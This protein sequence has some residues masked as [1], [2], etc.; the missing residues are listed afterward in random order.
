[1]DRERH[2]IPGRREPDLVGQ[3]PLLELDEFNRSVRLFTDEMGASADGA[4][5][6]AG[7]RWTPE[8]VGLINAV[9]KRWNGLLGVG[10]RTTFE[11]RE[12]GICDGEV[13][14]TRSFAEEVLRS[15]NFIIGHECGHE[16]ERIMNRGANGTTSG[17]KE[18]ETYY[19]AGFEDMTHMHSCPPFGETMHHDLDIRR[20]FGGEYFVRGPRGSQTRSYLQD[21]GYNARQIYCD[22]VPIK[23]IMLKEGKG[24]ISMQDIL[25]ECCVLLER[26]HE[27]L[28]MKLGGGGKAWLGVV[29]DLARYTGT[30]WALRKVAEAWVEDPA[31]S[32]EISARLERFTKM[33]GKLLLEPE[34]RQN[35]LTGEQAQNLLETP[36]LGYSGTEIPSHSKSGLSKEETMAVT[37]LTRAYKEHF[38]NCMSRKELFSDER[39]EPHIEKLNNPDE[40]IRRQEAYTLGELAS[41]RA[42]RPLFERLERENEPQVLTTIAKSIS[43]IMGKNRVSGGIHELKEDVERNLRHSNQKVILEM[44][45][46][47]TCVA[48]EQTPGK[49]AEVMRANWGANGFLDRGVDALREIG[50]A[51]GPAAEKA[52]QALVFVLND[53]LGET[54]VVSGM[55]DALGRIGSNKG[56]AAETAYDKLVEVIEANP[57]NKEI[58]ISGVFALGEIGSSENPKADKVYEEV[59]RIMNRSPYTYFVQNLGLGTLGKIACT[60]NP[61]AVKAYRKMVSM[62]GRSQD[63]ETQLARVT[64][65]SRVGS[66]KGRMARQAIDDL[67]LEIESAAEPIFKRAR[68]SA[69]GD[70]CFKVG[71]AAG[72]AY[73]VLVSVV[74]RVPKDP[75]SLSM[76]LD[77]LGKVASSESPSSKAAYDKI[78]EILDANPQ[79]P[80]IQLSG[81]WALGDIMNGKNSQAAL[82]SDR[83]VQV[84]QSYPHD[85]E[86]QVAG[87][88]NLAETCE[89]TDPGAEA[90][91]HKM[92]AAIDANLQDSK[93]QGA[94]LSALSY[95]CS[96]LSPL[97]ERAYYKMVEIIEANPQSGE[98]QKG[99]IWA[100]SR[101]ASS[102]NSKAEEAFDR[103]VDV[104][105]TSPRNSDGLKEGLYALGEIGSSDSPSAAKA[106][107]K[108][109]QLVKSDPQPYFKDEMIQSLRKI[110]FSSRPAAI[111]ASLLL[112]EME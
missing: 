79:D 50:L 18:A 30:A 4:R 52:L 23:E 57:Q 58:Q 104:I 46:A 27:D 5:K 13:N 35:E 3:V 107:E 2:P 56:L 14:F 34:S 67:A 65:I 85:T 94:G 112:A 92:V 1:M 87:V 32:R 77:A 22:S 54:S 78:V 59:E 95:I 38:I 28:R 63:P 75:Q 74:D 43:E 103:L 90:S 69:L 108:L 105:D 40:R 100:L 8:T 83:M 109:A 55:V 68:M 47:A 17:L 39:M 93:I 84:M 80:V 51:E 106:F 61:S 53:H 12:A 97:A 111:N 36:V 88:Y 26:R 70:I 20:V 15:P 102:G 19:N 25:E 16:L 60:N 73:E 9:V 86:I 49:I 99:K 76:G 7:Y 11:D 72:Y 64:L 81:V 31:K 82:A 24:P 10:V 21:I 66:G 62:T 37:V 6:A 101:V 29:P 110:R 91:Y 89:G 48:D 44:M 33:F 41:M 71:P 96:S 98:V 42:L 45:R